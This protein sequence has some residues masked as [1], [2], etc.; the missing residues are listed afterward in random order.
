MERS[1]LKQ[2]VI[3]QQTTTWP[4]PTV[5]RIIDT[6]PLIKGSS[7]AVI[8]GVRRCGKSTLL[9]WIRQRSQESAYYI[10]FD[11][12]RL[13]EF[14][15]KDFQ[16][17]LE[18]FG[19]LYG[20][21]H[22]FF[23][24]EIQNVPEWER[25]VRRLHDTNNKVYLTGSNATLFSQEL[26]TRLTGRY[27]QLEL[28][29]FSFTE[30]LAYHQQSALLRLPLTT[31]RKISFKRYFNR[32]V[33]E[34][35]IPEYL[36]YQQKDY[37][38][39]L[40]ESVIYRD[41]LARYKIVNERVIKELGYFLASNLGKE[42]TY[43]ALRKLLGVAS[44]S[45]ISDYC[46]YFENSFL[47]F[48]INR[49]DYSLKKQIHYAKKIY[50]VDQALATQVGFR[51]SEDNGRRLENIVFIELKRRGQEIYFHQATKECDFLIREG[52]SI[53]QAL[54]VCAEFRSKETKQRE[55]NGLIEAMQTYHLKEGFILTE[56]TLATEIVKQGRKKFTIH[57]RPVWAWLSGLSLE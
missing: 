32:F 17:L 15:V 57:I 34:G 54:Q 33:Q 5:S 28:Y 3:D 16:A 10:N 6:T 8:I 1:L 4:T 51:N 50:F 45:T 24:D 22:T 35:G 36:H 52:N 9:Q 53:T 56:D 37:L 29:P 40:Y 42:V 2:V 55:L 39:F 49:F 38:H 48:F 12:E 14:T 19:E 21:Q 41:I 43:N 18:I 20:E 26:G 11:D 47:C 7:I 44:P 13:V 23:F 27:L 25:F 31:S 30:Y 46:T